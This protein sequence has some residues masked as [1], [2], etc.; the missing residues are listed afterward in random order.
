MLY[1]YGL[2]A[3]ILVK[4]KS[5]KLYP[6]TSSYESDVVNLPTI[7]VAKS[8]DDGKLHYGGMKKVIDHVITEEEYGSAVF[9]VFRAQGWIP[10]GATYMTKAQAAAVTDIGLAFKDNTDIT[11]ATFLRWFTG[12]TGLTSY[13]NMAWLG[14]VGCTNLERIVI[15]CNVTGSYDLFHQGST[16][17][18]YVEILEGVTQTS[19]QFLKDSCDSS[20]CIVKFPSTYSTPYNNSFGRI[21][22]GTGIMDLRHTKIVTIYDNFMRRSF[23]DREFYLPSTLKT[24]GTGFMNELSDTV[25]Y[26]EFDSDISLSIGNDSVGRNP[27]TV[28]ASGSI[29]VNF[30]N[31]I[32]ITIGNSFGYGAKGTCVVIFHSTTLPTIGT[33]FFRTSR[34]ATK[35]YVPDEMVDA[36]KGIANLANFVNRIFP[37]SEYDGEYADRV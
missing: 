15:P 25:K 2:Y 6:S 30:K 34:S 10:Q 19:A 28:T 24:T 21:K 23:Y 32:P 13:K 20:G 18:K 16:K 12:L 22:S 9:N 29:T 26:I 27:N 11:D 3:K 35:I 7:H 36:Y 17:M 1:E 4:M 14:F 37:L 33:D 8:K 31:D 5:I